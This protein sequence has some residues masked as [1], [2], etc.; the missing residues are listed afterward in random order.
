MLRRTDV[1][2]RFGGEEFAVILPDTGAESALQIAERLRANV[3]QID[4][5]GSRRSLSISIG[6]T[7]CQPNASMTVDQI[8]DMADKALLAAKRRGR[9]RVE[10]FRTA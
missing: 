7:T 3:A 5:Q 2:G 1:I 4:V 9:N 6:V 10:R 8:L